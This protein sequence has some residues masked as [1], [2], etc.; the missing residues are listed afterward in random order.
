MQFSSTC[1]LQ[2]EEL[3]SELTETEEDAAR[4]REACEMEVEAAKSA[5]EERDIMVLYYPILV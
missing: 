3:I 1:D 4:W 2:I 5:M